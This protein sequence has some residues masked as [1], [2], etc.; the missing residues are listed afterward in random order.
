MR[1]S[2]IFLLALLIISSAVVGIAQHPTDTVIVLPLKSNSAKAEFNWVGESFA[3]ALPELLAN[4]GLNVISNT[5]RKIDQIKL[6][7]S[8]DVVPS[9][10]TSLKL[11]KSANATLVV[12][13]NYDVPPPVEGQPP[14]IYVKLQIV[15]VRTGRVLSEDFENGRKMEF[16]VEDALGNLQ[17][18]HGQLAHAILFRIDKV[19]YKLD[20][21]FPFTENDFVVA[22]TKIP[23]KA[24]ESYI[25]G[26]VTDDATIKENYLKN[27]M[28]IFSA[29]PAIR[30]GIY[31][32]AAVELGHLY[33]AQQKLADAVDSFGQVVSSFEACRSNAKELSKAARCNEETF[34][35]VAFYIGLIRWQQKNFEQ[36]LGALRPLSDDLKLLSVNNLLG[37]ISIQASRTE[38]KN[39]ARSAALLKDGLELLKGE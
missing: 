8:L 14:K 24:F 39:D 6:N 19:L 31:T 12:L 21:S 7:I 27:A 37:A 9:L 16:F 22:A 11:A 25:K 4:R 34:A 26:I 30:E 28:K 23:P 20:Q 38:K 5:E 32:E 1:I 3:N 29:D 36:A 10:A 35:E 13:G 15:N 17:T 2:S 18:V 33:L